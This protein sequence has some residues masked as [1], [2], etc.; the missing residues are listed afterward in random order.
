MEDLLAGTWMLNSE[1]SEFGPNHR[2]Q[3]GTMVFE[4][5]TEG[6]YLMRAEGV[7]EKGEKCAERPQKFVADGQPHPVP[8]FPGLTFVCTRADPRTMQGEVRREDG[9]IVG[10]GLYVIAVDGKSM[11]V[12]NSGWDSQLRQFS[13]KTAW[14]RL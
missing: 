6:H 11:T 4:I 14:D 1:K 8:D 3:D 12:T 9:S 13:Q 10:Q 5:D 7:N 2:P